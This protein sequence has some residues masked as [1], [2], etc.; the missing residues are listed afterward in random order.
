M[1]KLVCSFTRSLVIP[2]S[3]QA[4]P[5]LNP[6]LTSNLKTHWVCFAARGDLERWESPGQWGDAAQGHQAPAPVVLAW[7]L[8]KA[9]PNAQQEGEAEAVL[10]ICHQPKKVQTCHQR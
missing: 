9:F 8:T 10:A 5:G 7:T 6:D 3:C 4:Q 1:T 2:A